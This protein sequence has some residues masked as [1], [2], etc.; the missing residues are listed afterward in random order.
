M[1]PQ[2]IVLVIQ[3]LALLL[4]ANKHGKEKTGKENFWTTFVAGCISLSLLYWGGFYDVIVSK[5]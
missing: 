5:F 2:I 4:A 3:F 1:T